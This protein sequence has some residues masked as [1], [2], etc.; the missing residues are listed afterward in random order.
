MC[1]RSTSVNT[2]SNVSH[3]VVQLEQTQHYLDLGATER[4]S[5]LLL[6]NSLKRSAGDHTGPEQVVIHAVLFR[7]PRRRCSSVDH[8]L[9]VSQSCRHR[10]RPISVGF[11]HKNIVS[12]N[13]LARNTQALYAGI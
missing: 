5:E 12:S 8:L 1:C 7:T 6:F 4:A 3:V 13:A 2:Q 11:M 9:S 10:R